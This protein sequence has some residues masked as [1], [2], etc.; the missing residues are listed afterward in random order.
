MQP[1]YEPCTSEVQRGD[2]WALFTDPLT[3]SVSPGLDEK[4]CLKQ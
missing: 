4:F 1:A 2:P 3:E